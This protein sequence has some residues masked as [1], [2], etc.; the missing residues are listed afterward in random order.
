MVI[1][2]NKSGEQLTLLPF[3]ENYQGLACCAANLV[4]DFG[5]ESADGCMLSTNGFTMWLQKSPAGGSVSFQ[6][7]ETAPLG[8]LLVWNY[9]RIAEDG[10]DYTLCGLRSIEI[11]HSIDGKQWVE[12]QGKGYP[13]CLQKATGKNDMQPTNLEGGGVIDFGGVTARYI[14]LA[15]KGQPGVYNYDSENLFDRSFGLAKLR[16]Y[17]GTGLYTRPASAWTGL[18]ERR[19]G[20]AGA[21]GVYST[22]FNGVDNEPNHT[23]TLL[24]FGDTFIGSRIPGTDKRSADTIMINNSGCILK[25]G[26]PD[27]DQA[28]F[29]YRKQE[30][31]T[32]KS[33]ILPDQKALGIEN[34]EP[35][36]WGQDSMILH[37][38]YY[39]FPL[40]VREDPEGVEGY[41]FAVEGPAFLSAPVENGEV[42]WD[43]MEQS[44]CP[45]FYRDT[46]GTELVF[47]AAVFQ[48]TVE[49][50]AP[51][52]DGYLY[53]YGYKPEYIEKNLYAARIKAEDFPQWDKVEYY[54]GKTWRPE[55]EKAACLCRN[56]S[57]EMSF[58]PYFGKLY[59][60]KYIM[61]FTEFTNSPIVACRIADSPVGPFS[62]SI[63][64]YHCPEPELGYSIYT[65][66]AKAHPHLSEPGRLL[67]SYNAN[68]C[69]MAANQELAM[70]YSPRFIEVCE[71]CEGKEEHEEFR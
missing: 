1:K 55:I 61:V 33:L 7:E 15:W 20:W 62:D 67:V 32:P 25:E 36:F 68:A 51:N 45:L 46:D 10:T 58:S 4:N 24:M 21:D 27:V 56:I 38:R 64:L 65:Y 2:M 31:G 49:A 3:G 23:R 14:R 34:R 40:I 17:C 5:M 50:K 47:G 43:K 70:I 6:L 30:D 26:T 11:Y 19:D 66:N 59:E 57:C 42:L 52:P 13:Y 44:R 12:L 71:V 29:L 60:G 69:S 22:P 18:L 39:A 8:K 54:D 53:I 35:F 16:L 28:E 41:Q 48:N 9:N 63:R 37:G